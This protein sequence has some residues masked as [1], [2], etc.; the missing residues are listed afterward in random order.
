VSQRI[1]R[2]KQTLDEKKV[3][4]ASPERAELPGRISAVLR[5]LYSI[6]NEGHTGRT[7][8]LM[9]LD[10]QVE[11]LRLARVLCDLVPREPEAFGALAIMAFGAARAHT[12]V[13]GEGLP[14]LLDAQDRS[15]WNR[16]LLHE[17]LMALRRA[18]SL[19]GRGP[20]VLQAVIAA[21]HVTAP[22]WDSTDW[23]A[24]VVAYDALAQVAP[25]PIVA[26]NRAIA[27]SMADGP[28]AGLAALEKLEAP[29]EE[30][31]LFYAARADMLERAGDDPRRDL[32]RALSLA[33]N[34]AEKRL[35]ERRVRER[36]TRS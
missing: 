8:A 16:E 19:E 14:I 33:T 34:D 7:G 10:L 2:A 5:V 32:E 28:I 27:V 13:D 12:R 30:Y 9:R 3:G 26:L 36:L 31:H 17:G 29:L 21:A 11:A 35:L 1:L 23:R 18:R 6:F 22:A 4:Y 24:I 15:R 20:Y 25:S